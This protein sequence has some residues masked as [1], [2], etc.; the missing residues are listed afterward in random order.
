M[1]SRIEGELQTGILQ[2]LS[3]RFDL[4]LGFERGQL[5]SEG[6]A[7]LVRQEVVKLGGVR[8]HPA[9]K[10]LNAIQLDCGDALTW[11]KGQQKS[12]VNN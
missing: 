11:K 6:A 9:H 5:E 4:L 1:K 8:V 7:V 3:H 12:F 2:V 10:V